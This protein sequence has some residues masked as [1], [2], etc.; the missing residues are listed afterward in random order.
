MDWQKKKKDSIFLNVINLNKKIQR[1]VIFYEQ[2]KQRSSALKQLQAV[3][4]LERTH[5]IM[6]EMQIWRQV[7]DIT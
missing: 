3:M 7:L 5:G 6:V 4:K 1:V 2:T